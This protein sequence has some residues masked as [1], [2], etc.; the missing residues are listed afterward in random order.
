MLSR[1]WQ[2]EHITFLCEI[3]FL[4]FWVGGWMVRG[5]GCQTQSQLDQNIFSH[6]LDWMQQ[7]PWQNFLWC[8]DICVSAEDQLWCAYI[9]LSAEDQLWCGDVCLSAKE[10]PDVPHKTYMEVAVMSSI[11]CYPLH[12]LYKALWKCENGYLNRVVQLRIKAVTCYANQQ[13]LGTTRYFTWYRY[14]SLPYF[15]NISSCGE[16]VICCVLRWLWHVAILFG[17]CG[18]VSCLMLCFMAKL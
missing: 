10:Q 14:F 4:F 16:D 9:C 7:R 2:Q 13:R 12:Y 3:S 1:V 17:I 18:S 11:R 8:A 15:T 5:E 6:L